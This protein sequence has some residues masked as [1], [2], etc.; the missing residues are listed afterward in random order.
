MRRTWNI[1]VDSGFVEL[2][3]SDTAGR[4]HVPGEWNPEAER[5]LL[6]WIRRLDQPGEVQALYEEL[7]PGFEPRSAMAGAVSWAQ[8]LEARALEALRV[9][10]LMFAGATANSGGGGGKPKGPPAPKP[11]PKPVPPPKPPENFQ[12]GIVSISMPP[13][14]A[15]S[16]EKVDIQYEINDPDAKIT[17]ATF[18]VFAKDVPDPIFTEQL[19]AGDR[20]HG[21][22]VKKWDGA[23]STKSEFPDGFATIEFSPYTVRIKVA[24]SGT[25]SPEQ[26]ETTFEVKLA[27][28]E[29]MLGKKETLK[30]D[31]DKEVYDQVGALPASKKVELTLKRNLYA[32][33]SSEMNDGTAFDSLRAFW[34]DGPR[35]PVIATAFV[36]DSAGNAK[37]CGKAMGRARV[38]WD[39][40][41]PAE[42][43][44]AFKASTAKAFIDKALTHDAAGGR[45]K[46][47]NAHLEF[48]GKRGPDAGRSLPAFKPADSGLV[49]FPFTL[50]QPK[51]RFWASYGLFQKSGDDD[52]RAGAVFRASRFAGDNFEV[53]ALLDKFDKLDVTDDAPA[54]ELAKVK[55][56][57]FEVLHEVTLAEYYKK[58]SKTS[59]MS[60]AIDGVYEDS[61][62]KVANRMGA[63]KVIDKAKYDEL[64]QKGRG[65]AFKNAAVTALDTYALPKG[66]QYDMEPPVEGILGT[67]VDF[68]GDIVEAVADFLGFGSGGPDATEWVG[69]VRSYAKFK[70]ELKKGNS[71]ND[72]QLNIFLMNNGLETEQ[73]YC[74]E[75]SFFLGDVAVQICKELCT[76]EGVTIL[77]FSW[78]HSL[79]EMAFTS[80][81]GS[82]RLNGMAC[83]KTRGLTGFVFMQPDQQTFAHELG[84]C[85]FLPHAPQTSSPSNP[86]GGAQP[87]RH[88][89]SEAHCYMSYNPPFQG[90]CGLC[91][92]RMRGYD[93]SKFNKGGVAAAAPAGPPPGVGAPPATP[94]EDLELE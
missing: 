79:E 69:T 77:Q 51:K 55:V 46:G 14:M 2:T 19:G 9:G 18:E 3:V 71:F 87:D 82:I 70:S 24:G 92:L 21:P 53:T 45:P 20:T 40:T 56:G 60:P 22:H 29:V 83:F 63:A 36:Q 49:S 11:K 90:F 67:I 86:V 1:P 74:R 8:S 30:Y 89:G 50:E 52:G 41:D 61:Y 85:L 28:F 73:K 76:K 62:T 23:V 4:F 94:V 78:T 31:Q 84:H 58:A 75:L 65:A 15:P 35:I 72:T 47:D 26:Q 59:P 27:K 34:D 6:D 42:T 32:T 17:S 91:L 25:A 48:G 10:D 54:G 13:V 7:F 68:L 80:I 44:T 5:A 66:S 12:F 57:A 37:R 39:Y 64:F 16:A 43:K 81:A 38:L 93:Q 88:D 33:K